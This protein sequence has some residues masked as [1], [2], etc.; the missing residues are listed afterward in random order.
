[1][2]LPG[3]EL[4]L[5]M[6]PNKVGMFFDLK[7]YIDPTMWH[8]LQRKHHIFWPLSIRK[9]KKELSELGLTCINMRKTPEPHP[10]GVYFGYRQAGRRFFLP[11]FFNTPIIH[12]FVDIKFK[13]AR[14]SDTKS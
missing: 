9:M 7:H 13:K 5:G 6:V 14:E 1:V 10:T 8:R 12:N 11:L 2:L 3:G 4:I